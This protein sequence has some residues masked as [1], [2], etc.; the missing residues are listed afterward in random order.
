MEVGVTSGVQRQ[1]RNISVTG[2][3]NKSKLALRYQVKYIK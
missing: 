1:Q 3:S 2:E